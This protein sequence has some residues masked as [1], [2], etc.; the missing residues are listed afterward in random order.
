MRRWEAWY[1]RCVQPDGLPFRDI[2]QM[3]IAHKLG[4][5]VSL[6]MTLSLPPECCRKH[7][8]VWLADDRSAHCCSATCRL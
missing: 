1:I 8:N 3:L 7:A 6:H 4:L 2:M 5:N